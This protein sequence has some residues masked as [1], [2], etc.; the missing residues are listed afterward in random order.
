[1]AIAD[2]YTFPDVV[3]TNE[4]TAAIVAEVEDR[5]KRGYVNTAMTIVMDPWCLCCVTYAMYPDEGV[6]S[7]T[8]LAGCAVVPGETHGKPYEITVKVG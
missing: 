3:P 8:T 4:L 6:G 5:E 2:T 7:L 1:M